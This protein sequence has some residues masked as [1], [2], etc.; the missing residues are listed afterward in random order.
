MLPFHMMWIVWRTRNKVIF[1]DER[2]NVYSIV[3]QIITAVQH[4]SIL[5]VKRKKSVRILGKPPQMIYP[6]GFIDGASNCTVV[7]AGF[8]I[9]INDYHHME[10]SL[11][12]GHGT[13]TKAKLLSLWAILLTSHMMGIPLPRYMVIL[14]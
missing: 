5:P 2:R 9:Y 11:G 6:C 4:L 3:C 12:V 7:G 13:N 1:E 8:C 14:L 10:F